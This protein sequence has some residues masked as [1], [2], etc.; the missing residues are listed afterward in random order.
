MKVYG[1]SFKFCWDGFDLAHRCRFH[2][3]MRIQA[4]KNADAC[5]IGTSVAVSAGL[6]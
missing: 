6:K 3:D 5:F 2:W 4:Y 1:L